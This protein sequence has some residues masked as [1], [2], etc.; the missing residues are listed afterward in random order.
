MISLS[1][2]GMFPVPYNTES[3]AHFLWWLNLDSLHGFQLAE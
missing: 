3:Y 1:H 2:W